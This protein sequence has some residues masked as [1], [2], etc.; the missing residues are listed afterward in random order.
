[1]IRAPGIRR[2]LHTANGSEPGYD[3]AGFAAGATR[4]ISRKMTPA[5][6][7]SGT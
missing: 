6:V 7:P 1:M 4:A 2:A 5:I 3:I